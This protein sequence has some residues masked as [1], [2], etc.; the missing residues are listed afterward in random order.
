MRE[1]PEKSGTSCFGRTNS[2]RAIHEQERKI[3]KKE[4]KISEN[5]AKNKKYLK[6]LNK[7]IKLY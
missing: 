2:I 1:V 5:K 3:V 6:N 7:I 4:T